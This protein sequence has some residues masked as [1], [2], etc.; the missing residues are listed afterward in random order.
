MLEIKTYQSGSEI[1]III[2]GNE[3]EVEKEVSKIEAQYPPF[4]Y[5]TRVT[6][7]E[8]NADGSIRT[9]VKRYSHCD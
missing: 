8:P 7:V 3:V 9:T 2:T 5:Q 1:T 4:G 6:K